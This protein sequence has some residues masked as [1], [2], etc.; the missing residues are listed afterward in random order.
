[1]FVWNS[2]LDNQY[3]TIVHECGII[4]L[5]LFLLMVVDSLMTILK[6]ED[7]T[8]LLINSSLL[9]INIVLFFFEGLDYV[10]VVLFLVFLYVVDN[11]EVKNKGE[12]EIVYE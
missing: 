3:L 5:I 11:K 6:S 7:K 10:T 12:V 4:G 2:A 8:R 9:S 1:M